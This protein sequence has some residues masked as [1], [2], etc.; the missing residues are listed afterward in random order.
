MPSAPVLSTAATSL[1]PGSFAF[2]SVFS[3]SGSAVSLPESVP[4]TDKLPVLPRLVTTGD[5][6][7]PNEP[8]LRRFGPSILGGPRADEILL[9]L[10]PE[11][12]RRIQRLMIRVYDEIESGIG[13]SGDFWKSAVEIDD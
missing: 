5:L 3:R 7:D 13:G 4:A 6:V 1:E 9:R 11:S 8:A 2:R 12:R 10:S